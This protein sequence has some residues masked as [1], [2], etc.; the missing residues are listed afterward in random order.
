[1]RGSNAPAADIQR[2]SDDTLDAE[3]LECVHGADNINDRVERTDLVQMDF[4]HWRVVNGCFRIRKLRKQRLSALFRPRGERSSVDQL[5]YFCECSVLGMAMLV[6][7]AMHMDVSGAVVVHMVGRRTL[8]SHPQLGRAH[9]S[10]RH[11]FGPD[12]LPIEGEAPQR[13]PKAVKREACVEQSAQNHVAGGTRETIEIEE[14]HPPIILSRVI[15]AAADALTQ[16]V[17]S[18]ADRQE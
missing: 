9:T 12:G 8:T 15:Q 7:G 13:V 11:A 4:V 2:R 6:I 18:S 3:R 10:P 14:G 17:R 5:K 16:P 1:V